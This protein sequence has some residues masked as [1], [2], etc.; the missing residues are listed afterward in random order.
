MPVEGGEEE[1]VL[2]RLEKESSFHW[3]VWGVAD[4]GIYFIEPEGKSGAVLEFYS[5]RTKRVTRVVAM[6]KVPNSLLSVAPDQRWL[7]YAQDEMAY[8]WSGWVGSNIMLV[9]NFR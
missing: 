5:L 3:Q 1:L 2:D 7:V 6:E 8:R 4:T 9:E